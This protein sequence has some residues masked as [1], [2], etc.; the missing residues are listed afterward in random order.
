M[1]K[2]IL[3]YSL[4][5]I[6][7]G[8][9]SCSQKTE[10]TTPPNTY[11]PNI[12]ALKSYTYDSCAIE[13]V[14]NPK[15]NILI[16][17]DNSTSTNLLSNKMKEAIVDSIYFA[18]KTFDYRIFVAPLIKPAGGEVLS[19]YPAFSGTPTGS[20]AI[21]HVASSKIDA[22]TFKNPAY[23]STEK[24]LSRTKKLLNFNI[25]QGHFRKNAHTFTVLISN[26]DDNEI[27]YHQSSGAS[28][29]NQKLNELKAVKK[30]I[31]PSGQK[32]FRLVSVVPHS[33][34]KKGYVIGRQYRAMSQ[35][36]YALS[37]DTSQSHT[38][39]PDTF[40][41][42][43]GN[44][45]QIFSQINT[46]INPIKENL[47]YAHWP[48][49]PEIEA[50]VNANHINMDNFQVLT[51]ETKTKTRT[52]LTK[53]TD[54]QYN[55]KFSGSLLT[56][57]HINKLT[58]KGHAL[59]LLTPRAQITTPDCISVKAPEFS[60]HY[61][62]IPVA[63]KPYKASIQLSINGKN[64]PESSTDGWELLPNYMPSINILV[65]PTPAHITE[66]K[67]G[68]IIKLNG[69]AVFEDGSSV[70]LSFKKDPNQE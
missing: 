29:F 66:F 55:K 47:T 65:P 52:K 2:P 57:G 60:K 5:L 42:C 49:S 46:S 30:S 31:D 51:Y 69:S 56:A 50:K 27:A 48:I 45:P 15:V 38:H 39:F 9:I 10:F 20:T 24:G 64:I 34:C 67:A 62:Y 23:G 28:M 19:Q 12:S 40:D 35:S 68:Y 22:L 1:K 37:G 63:I 61:G 59:D 14:I 3:L 21:P 32:Q 43:S 70:Q 8:F 41:L 33:Y 18:S 36:L 44:F 13:G 26:G 17:I 16:L 58:H 11:N 53:G 7:F 25:N 4:I 6:S 54:Y